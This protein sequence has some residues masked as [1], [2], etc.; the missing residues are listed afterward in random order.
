MRRES[1]SGQFQRCI[2]SG[3]P[4]LNQVRCCKKS[5]MLKPAPLARERALRVVEQDR[6]IKAQLPYRLQGDLLT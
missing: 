3:P 1:R 5:S 4:A 2:P 6:S